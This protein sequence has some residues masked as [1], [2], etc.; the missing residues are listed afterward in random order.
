MRLCTVIRPDNV[1]FI[2]QMLLLCKKLKVR[3]ALSLTLRFFKRTVHFMSY[4]SSV[5]LHFDYTHTACGPERFPLSHAELQLDFT[6]TRSQK[7]ITAPTGTLIF[8]LH[9]KI[10]ITP[11]HQ[12]DPHMVTLS[13]VNLNDATYSRTTWN[14]RRE[15][16]E[17]R[18]S[19]TYT[20][21]IQLLWLYMR[22]LVSTP[23]LCLNSDFLAFT[24]LWFCRSLHLH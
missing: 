7:H 24:Q 3:G 23:T 6:T 22:Q 14:T 21:L 12:S 20:R 5:F 13:L 17:R 15:H 4:W 2:S 16:R 9:H 18:C 10:H 8:F 19:M 11:Y 1:P